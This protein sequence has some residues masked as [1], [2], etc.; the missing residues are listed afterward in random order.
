MDP[1]YQQFSQTSSASAP[2]AP[3]RSLPVGDSAPQP[4]SWKELGLVKTLKELE[5]ETSKSE[6]TSDQDG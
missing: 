2:E 3:C 6:K 1:D 4:Y 5:T